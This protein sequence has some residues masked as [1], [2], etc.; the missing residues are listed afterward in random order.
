MLSQ[1]TTLALKLLQGQRL[2]GAIDAIH[3]SISGVGSASRHEIREDIDMRAADSGQL[4]K[5]HHFDWYMSWRF[6][7]MGRD[8]F[9]IGFTGTQGKPVV[10]NY[11]LR[12]IICV[13]HTR[14][15]NDM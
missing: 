8:E 12:G 7:W 1:L 10:L 2:V 14:L 6:D 13:L 4:G 9:K 5:K 3:D 15:S 11:V